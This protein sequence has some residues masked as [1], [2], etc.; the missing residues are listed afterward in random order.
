M[1]LVVKVSPFYTGRGWYDPKSGLNFRKEYGNIAIPE[2]KDLLNVKRDIKVNALVI[3]EGSIEEYESAKLESGVKLAAKAAEEAKLAA[4]KAK[5]EEEAK[6]AEEKAKEEA[7]KA[8]EEAK[9]EIKVEN[10]EED[11]PSDIIDNPPV[12]KKTNKKSS[13]KE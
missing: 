12:K 3:V 6:L 11:K 9:A 4:E 13:K 10:K 2:G 8:A 7:A 1:A 5:A